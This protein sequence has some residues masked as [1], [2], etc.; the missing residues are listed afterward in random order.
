MFLSLKVKPLSR[1]FP[2][3]LSERA[4]LVVQ[5][6]ITQLFCVFSLLLLTFS[7]SRIP[8]LSFSLSAPGTSA[9]AQEANN[10]ANNRTTRVCS[11]TTQIRGQNLLSPSLSL[12]QR[13]SLKPA[14][15][16]LLPLTKCFFSQRP[17]TTH[18]L[19]NFE[20]S[21][22]CSPRSR[23]SSSSTAATTPAGSSS[24]SHWLSSIPA[25]GQSTGRRVL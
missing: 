25:F 10:S 1:L 20:M 15:S 22:F 8:F 23:T 18:V 12:Q 17:T 5:G 19:V 11:C 6:L 3:F 2:S 21:C 9:C 7:L 16:R 14:K 13:E 4:F 24:S